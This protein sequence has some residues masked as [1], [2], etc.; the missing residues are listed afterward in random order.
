[1]PPH[2]ADSGDLGLSPSRVPGEPR[3]HVLEAHPRKDR[4][5]VPL[6]DAVVGNLV[7][8]CAEPIE[9]KL[10]VSGLR[11]LKGEHIDVGSREPGLNPIDA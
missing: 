4:H 3:R 10:V 8:E 6:V 9:G 1:M 7:P 11:L 2:V 5:P